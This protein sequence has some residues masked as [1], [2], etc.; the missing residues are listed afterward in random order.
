MSHYKETFKDNEK[1]MVSIVVS[2]I[3]MLL[4]TLITLGF[5]TIMQRELRQSSDRQYS[6]QAFYAAESGINDA[7]RALKQGGAQLRKTDCTTS[8]SSPLKKNGPVADGGTVDYTCL[9][10]ESELPDLRFS[11]V[12][13]SRGRQ[14]AIQTKDGASISRLKFEWDRDVAHTTFPGGTSLPSALAWPGAAPD[15]MR[16]TVFKRISGTNYEAKN[17]YLIP[18]AGGPGTVNFSDPDGQLVQASC[19]QVVSGTKEYACSAEIL[20]D[21]PTTP[22]VDASEDQGALVVAFYTIY[23]PDATAVRVGGFQT[24][25]NAT[26]RLLVNSQY[27]I[28]S[29]GKANDVVRRIEV[30]VSQSA[31][32]FEPGFGLEAVSG[33]CKR[34]ITEPGSTTGVASTCL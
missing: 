8:A 1:G 34:F 25:D 17:F 15:M 31:D 11:D 20:G 10:I 27:R 13:P 29:Q 26:Q 14:T 2:M 16:V 30:R 22:R 12:S 3:M 32:T 6:L 23:R 18:S 28:D 33:I 24:A 5:T 9:Q 21:F 7:Y 4:I 19:S